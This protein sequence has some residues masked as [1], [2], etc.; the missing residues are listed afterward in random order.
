MSGVHKYEGLVQRVNN[1]EVTGE[2]LHHTHWDDNDHFGTLG[3]ITASTLL[4]ANRVFTLTA[5]G[6][7]KYKIKYLVWFVRTSWRL[8]VHR[9]YYTVMNISIAN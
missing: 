7:I 1:Q 3:P 5:C 9:Q 6:S 4:P 8:P 2:M